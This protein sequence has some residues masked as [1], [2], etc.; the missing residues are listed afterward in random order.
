MNLIQ[1][2]PFLANQVVVADEISVPDL[3]SEDIRVHVF[4]LRRIIY[5]K[6]KSIVEVTH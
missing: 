3:Y 5:R 6:F 1:V 2:Y 4:G